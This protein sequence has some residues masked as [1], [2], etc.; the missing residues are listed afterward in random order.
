[1]KQRLPLLLLAAAFAG[2]GPLDGVEPDPGEKPDGST[3]A[4]E[5]IRITDN[6]DGSFTAV[7]DATDRDAWVGLDLDARREVD[8]TLDAAWD[9]SFQRFL[10]R[11]R[12]GVNGTGG[13]EG[14]VITGIAFESLTT[15]PADGY[16]V[17]Q[18][19]GED[20]GSD[21]DTVF[22]VG[23]G[24][25]A[26]D[27]ATHKLTP[28]EQLYVVR[29]DAGAYVKLQFQG[30]YDEA[31]T[32]AV[33]TV[34]FAPIDGPR[35]PGGDELVVDASDAERWTFVKIG[36]GVVSVDS[37]EASSEWDLAF[38]RTQIRTN[39]GVSGAGLGGARLAPNTDFAA[40]DAASTLGFLVDEHLPIP[41]PNTGATAPGNPALADWFDYDLST[42]LVSPKDVVFLVRGASGEYAKL[43]ILSYDSGSYT[44]AIEPIARRVETV[45]LEVDASDHGTWIALDLSRGVEED[46]EALAS[47][48]AWDLAIKRTQFMTNSGTS[49]PGTAGALA[50]DATDFDLVVEA[51]A[52]GYA[53]DAMLPVQGPGGGEYSG[54]PV[55]ADWFDYDMTTHTPSPK[56]RVFVVRTAS[57]GFAKLQV[58]AYASGKYTLRFAYSGPGTH[59][60]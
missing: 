50:I 26:Y 16:R 57:G 38:R 47:S 22:N 45:T 33:I 48:T 35:V 20:D 44:L 52:D 36:A 24:W 12:G 46:V 8:A 59:L 6:A 51:P 19:D 40:I 27:L 43:R 54:N 18:H 39:S 34:R 17:D 13:V 3:G 1:M 14:A 37:P 2:C 21:P 60:F 5:R 41:G 15:A 23:E 4:V 11:S 28:R 31:G 58:L 56:D 7:V 25:Y 9:L 49:G 10:V 32:P 29:T 42:H 30:Y 55:L 53:A